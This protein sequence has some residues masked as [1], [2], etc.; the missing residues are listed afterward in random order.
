M[1]IMGQLIT[2]ILVLNFALYPQQGVAQ[3]KADAPKKVTFSLVKLLAHELKSN[4]KDYFSD[5]ELSQK[6][7]IME[8]AVTNSAVE[9]IKKKL[10]DESYNFGEIKQQIQAQLLLEEQNKLIELKNV[11]A[12][13]SP[14]K[15]DV[16]FKQAMKDGYYA[17]DFKMSYMSAYNQLEKIE[18]LM[19]M[20]SSDLSMIRSQNAKQIGLMTRADLLKQLES[21]GTLMTYKNDKVIMV[22]IIV[23]TVAVAGLATWGII[24]ATKARHERKKK[25][26]ND[27]F[28]QAEQD[29]I[30]QHNQDIKT[31]EQ[32]FAE[33]ERLRE[34][35]YVWQ[36]CATTTTMKTASCS[37]DFKT[38]AGEEVCVTHCL[39]Q[40]QTGLEAMHSKS[41]LSSYIPNNCFTKNP[42]AAGY[43]DGYDSGY[44]HGY[45]VGYDRG[46]DN[47]YTPAYNNAYSS[48]YNSGYDS[49]YS[50]GFSSGYSDGAADYADTEGSLKM[51]KPAGLRAILTGEEDE[52]A[53]GYKKGFQ[54]GY[55]YALQL[56]VGISF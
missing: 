7:A 23:L 33:R 13:A 26:L 14:D 21:T 48:A 54:E 41:C 15:L 8:K 37:Y 2:Y 31:L 28:D 17:E 42:T 24:S 44:D 10:K 56:K 6:E 16:F 1:K 43:D 46:Y 19:Q 12:H 9:D 39:K 32:V 36:V 34:E 35:G 40:P 18:V 5:E 38:H 50:S 51:L 11:L 45:D 20:L 25:E 30:N 47:A 55:A 3:V 22:L 49:G 4:P 27:Q 52:R 29:A 53:L